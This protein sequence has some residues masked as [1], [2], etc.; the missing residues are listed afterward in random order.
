MRWKKLH[1]LFDIYNALGI[2]LLYVS[3]VEHWYVNYTLGS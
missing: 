2:N 1:T 3:P